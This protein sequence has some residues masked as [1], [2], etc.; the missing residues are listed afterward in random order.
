MKI[1]EL[2]T[3]EEVDFIEGDIISVEGKN[4]LFQVSLLWLLLIEERKLYMLI[5][6]FLRLIVGNWSESNLNF[7]Q[8][9]K[10][11]SIKSI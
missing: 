1:A 6:D 10:T 9:I 11:T 5:V 2:I 8:R 7:C 4:T 3:N